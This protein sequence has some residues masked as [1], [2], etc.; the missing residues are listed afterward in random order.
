MVVMVITC[1]DTMVAMVIT[2]KDAMVVMV[3]TDTAM[4][5][6]VIVNIQSHQWPWIQHKDIHQALDI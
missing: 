6:M 5:Y 2:C 1:K 4:Y 3:T